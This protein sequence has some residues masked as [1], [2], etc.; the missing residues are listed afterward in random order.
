MR[1]GE[2]GLT[3]RLAH[4]K[5]E[6]LWGPQKQPVGSLTVGLCEMSGQGEKDGAPAAYRELVSR[7]KTWLVGERLHMGRGNYL[8]T[9]DFHG[10]QG[11]DVSVQ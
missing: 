7:V 4:G 11:Q 1:L 10:D 8:E 2:L 6:A 3:P 5:T 9:T